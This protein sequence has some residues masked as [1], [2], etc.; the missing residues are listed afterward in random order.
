MK[1]VQKI[2]LLGIGKKSNASNK[3]RP[4]STRR[5]V[6]EQLER[7]DAIGSLLPFFPG[8]GLAPSIS[9]S[10]NAS[11]TREFERIGRVTRDSFETVSP[12]A[13]PNLSGVEKNGSDW[14]PELDAPHESVGTGSIQRDGSHA[15]REDVAPQAANDLTIDLSVD[16]GL[17]DPMEPGS[18]RLPSDATY[19]SAWRTPV[20]SNSAAATSAALSVDSGTTGLYSSGGV[21]DYNG[22]VS[23][24]RLGDNSLNN[25]GGTDG[26]NAVEDTEDGVSFYEDASAVPSASGTTV[27]PT[28]GNGE[29]A[30]TEGDESGSQSDDS[31]VPTNLPNLFGDNLAN[32]TVEQF[33][34]SEGAAGTVSALEDGALMREGD[35]FTVEMRRNLTVTPE[36]R[37][38]SFT[39]ETGFDSSDT[40][41]INDAFEAAFVDSEGYSLVKTF[42][43]YRDSFFNV[44]EGLDPSVGAQ[45]TIDETSGLRQ[46]TLDLTSV[47]DNMEGTLIFRM[48]NNDADFGSW[49]K[50]Y[51]TTGVISGGSAPEI[52]S[53]TLDP[54]NASE[55]AAVSLN[56]T[57]VDTDSGD[58][59]SAAINWGDGTVENVAVGA[60]ATGGTVAGSHVYADNGTYTVVLTVTDFQGESATF[61]RDVLVAN[62]APTMS[63][64]ALTFDGKLSSD[65]TV[66]QYAVLSG[67][68]TDP[69]FTYAPA[70]TAETFVVTV[71]WG[72]GS[73]E[74]YTPSVTQGSA[75]VLTFGEYSLR[76]NYIQGGIYN[77][78]VTVTDDDGGS[79]SKETRFG[80]GEITIAQ[81]VNRPIT[82]TPGLVLQPVN[83]VQRH[84]EIPVIVKS[85]GNLDATALDV[86]TARF[87]PGEASDSN[88]YLNAYDVAPYSDG[89]T[90]AVFH[91]SAYDATIRPVDKLGWLTA[92]FE[93]GTPFFGVDTIKGT[94]ISSVVPE[95][96][97]PR[98]AADSNTKFFVIDAAANSV[99]RYTPEGEENSDF[100]LSTSPSVR[101]ITSNVDGSK[102]WIVDA[103]GRA[104]ETRSPDGWKYG[105]WHALDM[106]DPQG[107]ATDGTDIWIVDRMLRSVLKYDGAASLREGTVT[108]DST[109]ELVSENM[110]P[111]GMATD[112]HT[113]WI[114]DDRVDSVFLYD[115]A[116]G[117]FLGSWALDLENAD[118]IGIT[119]DP[120]G[121]SDSIWILDYAD[122]LVYEYANA[123]AIVAGT[124]AVVGTFALAEGNDRPMGIV[125]PAV[126]SVASLIQGA[127]YD[128]D[129]Q[130][131]LSGN[132][133]SDVEGETIVATY[134]NGVVVDVAD[135][136]GNFF[137]A[138]Q[139]EPGENVYEITAI[140]SNGGRTTETVSIYGKTEADKLDNLQFDVSPSFKPDY[141]RTSFD[142]RL[143]VL[144]A[145]LAIENVGQYAADTPF[146]VGVRNI[147]DMNVVALDPVGVTKEG[148]PY[149]DVSDSIDGISLDPSEKTSWVNLSFS[150]PGRNRFT[151]EL[152]YVYKTNEAP[153]FVTA[154]GVEAYPDK[155]YSYASR[156]TDPNYDPLTYSLVVGP[157]GMTIDAQTGDLSWTPTELG[158]YSVVLRVEDGRGGSATQTYAINVV[159]APENRPPVIT[160][161]PVTEVYLTHDEEETVIVDPTAKTIV[162]NATVRDF[163]DSHPDFESRMGSRTGMVQGQ[164]GEDG[165]PHMSQDASL[166]P[167]NYT[168]TS[169]EYFDQWYN[170]VSGVNTTT[171]IP[172][173]LTETDDGSSVYEFQSGAFFPIDNQLFGNEGRNHNFHF[174]LECHTSF[175]YRGGE[176]FSFT[177]DDDIWVFIDG[178]LVVD[179]G[180]VHDAA[181]ASVSLDDLGLTPGKTYSFDLFFAER[182]TSASNF[183]IQTSI[184][185]GRTANYVYD[186]DATDPDGDAVTYSL[187]LAPEGMK[188]NASNGAITWNPTVDQIGENVVTVI[189]TDEHGATD[190]QTFSVMVYADP[191]NHD[192]IIISEPTTT[193][194]IDVVEQGLQND[195]VFTMP[196]VSGQV[197]ETEFNW[198]VSSTDY[199]NEFGIYKVDSADGVVNGV[200]P[201]DPNYASVA[202]SEGNYFVVFKSG[203]G[204]GAKRTLPLVAGQLYSFY[205]VANNSTENFLGNNPTN[206]GSSRPC[207]WF[208][209]PNANPDGNSDHLHTSV[210]NEGVTTFY[211]EDLWGLGDQDFNDVVFTI[212]SAL[213]FGDHAT[214]RYEV[215]AVDPD[216]DDITYELLYGPENSSINTQTGELTWITELGSYNF[217]VLASDGHG[218][219]DV[220]SFV[221]NVVEPGSGIISGY[222]INDANANGE[223]DQNEGFLANHVVWLDQNQNGRLDS[224]EISTKSDANG[225]YEFTGLPSG[226]YFVRYQ[227][228]NGWIQTFPSEGEWKPGENIVVNGDFE[229]AKPY[230]PPYKD[231][232]SYNDTANWVDG[233]IVSEGSVTIHSTQWQVANSGENSIDLQGL[234]VGSFSQKLQTIPG[235]KYLVQYAV[236]GDLTTGG[237]PVVKRYSITAGGESVTREFDTSG[238][239]RQNMGWELRSWMFTAN[240][241]E[242]ALTF[243]GLDNTFFGA[244]I[245]DVVVAPLSQ[246]DY[247][248]GYTVVLNGSQSA[249]NRNFGATNSDDLDVGS[250]TIVST[251]PNTATVGEVYRYDVQTINPSGSVLDFTL[252]SAPSGMGIHHDLGTIVWR[253][254]NADV[255]EY[256][257]VVKV[258]NAD[259]EVATQA[260]TIN[261]EAANH[262]PVITTDAIP[263][264]V[265]AASPY[266]AYIY[267]QDADNDALTYSL[268]GAPNGM[269]IDPDTGVLDCTPDAALIGTTIAATVVVTDARGKS[270][271]KTYNLSVVETLE[272]EAPVITSTPR[273]RARME[274]PYV[275]LIQA[276]DPNGDRL[277]FS[278]SGISADGTPLA[279]I[280]CDSDTGL[281]QWTP[282]AADQGTATITAS[283]SDGRGGVATQTYALDIITLAENTA[284]RILS[285]PARTGIVG[286]TWRYDA[287]AVDPDGDYVFWR[288]KDAPDGASINIETGEIVWVP[289]YQQLAANLFTVVCTD[290][291]GASTEQTFTVTVRGINRPPVIF[292]A[293]NSAAAT[294]FNYVYA[295]RAKDA[296]G[297]ELR[298][299]LVEGAYPE[300]MTIDENLGLVRWTPSAD[301]AG[302]HFVTI[303][304]DDGVGGIDTQT[305]SINVIDSALNNPPVITSVPSVATSVGSKYVYTVAAKDPDGDRI[306]YALEEGPE[307]ATFNA[308]TGRFEWSPTES[309]IG[310]VRIVF[311]ATDVYGK[312]AVQSYTL[313]VAPNQAPTIVSTPPTSA[314]PDAPYSYDVQAT[315]PERD[316]ITY[317][318][319][320]GPEGM[321]VDEYGRL[322]WTPDASLMN[323]SVSVTVAAID[324]YSNV[325]EQRFTVSVGEDVDA[326]QV[327]LIRD[328]SVVKPGEE[329]TVQVQAIDN[330]GVASVSLLVNGVEQPLVWNAKSQLYTAQLQFAN[331]GE[332]EVY[333]TAVDA[334]GNV[335][336]SDVAALRASEHADAPQITFHAIYPKV[337]SAETGGLVDGEPIVGDDL[338]RSPV[339]TYLADVDLSIFDD[340]MGSWIIDLA[341]VSAVDLS[342]L[343]AESEA[344]RVLGEGTGVISHRR[345]SLDPTVLANDAYVLRVRAYRTNGVGWCEAIVFG[346]EG[347]AKLGQFAFTT[348]DLH[349][350]RNGVSLTVQRAYDTA[351]ANTQGDFGYGWSLAICDPKIAE[352]T[353][354]G[355][356][357]SD[358][359]R[360]YLTTPDG[361]RIGFTYKPETKTTGGFMSAIMEITPRFEADPGVD[362]TLS[363]LDV[364]APK[365]SGIAGVFI[366]VGDAL[367]DDGGIFNPSNYVLTSKDGVS[368]YYRQKDPQSKRIDEETGLYKILDPNGIELTVTKDGIK[369]SAGGFLTFERDARGR[370]MSITDH[371]DMTVSYTY[372]AA[373]NLATFSNQI[374]SATNTPSVTYKYRN[375]PAHF[376][377]EAYD[378][379]GNR[380]FKAEFDDDGR[381]IGMVDALGNV[382]Q[383]EF[384]PGAMTGTTR[385][386]N[387]NVTTVWYD[388]RGNVTQE[389][390]AV[391]NILTGETTTYRQTYE[392]GDPRFPD[393]ETRVVNYD[394]TATEY[395]Y[396]EA[397][398]KTSMAYVSPDGTQSIVK[399]MAYD[400]EGRVTSEKLP[401]IPEVNYLY[402]AEGNPTGFVTATGMATSVFDDDGKEISRTDLHGNTTTMEYPEVCPC[403]APRLKVKPDGSYERRYW[404]K[405]SLINRVEYYNADDTLVHYEEYEYDALDRVVK[406][407]VGQG[408]SVHVALFEYDGDSDRVAVKTVVNPDDPSQ[409]Q[410]WYAFYDANGNLIRRVDPGVDVNDPNAGLFCKYDA[411]GNRIWIRD[412]VGNVTTWVYDSF[413]RIVEERD[414]SYWAERDVDWSTMTD[415]EI[416]EL[417]STPT[418]VPA[419]GVFSESHVSRFAYDG[420]DNIVDQIDP[421]GRRISYE[422]DYLGKLSKEIWY[423]ETDDITPI[424]VITLEHN[425]DG[426]LV[427]AKSPDAEYALTW[428]D[429]GAVESISVDYPW[430]ENFETFTITFGSEDGA[431]TERDSLGNTTY[432]IY[433]GNDG[434]AARWWKGGGVEDV[435][436]N[437]TYNSYGQLESVKRFV[438]LDD[439]TLVLSSDYSYNLS[440]QT[441]SIVHQDSLGQVLSELKYEYDFAGRLESETINRLASDMSRTSEYGYDAYGQIAFASYSG[442]QIDETFE[443]DSNGNSVQADSVVGDDNE[444]LSDGTY[445]YE[446]DSA[447]N[448]IAKTRINPIQGEANYVRYKYDHRNRLISVEQFSSK[449]GVLLNAES[450][451]YDMFNRR[452]LVQ[453]GNEAQISVYNSINSLANE[454]ARFDLDGNVIQR[455]MFGDNVDSLF[456]LWT[457]Q[458]G[459]LWTLSDRL[460]SI[461]DVMNSSG[462]VVQC[463]DYTSMGTPIFRTPQGGLENWSSMRPYGFT[464]RVW[465][466]A[467]GLYYFR[468]R[469]YDSSIGKFISKDPLEFGSGDTN[470]YRYI[471]N[472]PFAGTDP[473]GMSY[474][475]NLS[476]IYHV[477]L[478]VLIGSTRA[479]AVAFALYRSPDA[480]SYV[481]TLGP[482]SFA[483]DKNGYEINGCGSDGSWWVPDKI[484]GVDFTEACNNHDRCYQDVD[485]IQNHYALGIVAGYL[486]CTKNLFVD[487]VFSGGALGFVQ[488]T[489]AALIYYVGLTLEII[490]WEGPKAMYVEAKVNN[491]LIAQ[492]QQ[493]DLQRNPP[494]EVP[495]MWFP[496]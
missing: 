96:A 51:S 490:A 38:I 36:M 19:A 75:G 460:G 72:D 308:S 228:A 203:E 424:Y 363:C 126:I 68:F 27:N 153:I 25:G 226:A 97:D 442:S 302:L 67:T 229:K 77:A 172:L 230:S 151:Y 397:G 243:S 310:N 71:D 32:W 443:W 392:Y 154:P 429:S 275:Y 296:D 486:K 322:R 180:G 481:I 107:I 89:V 299:S 380:V 101:D 407:I 49:V 125:D 332:Y 404:N 401:G 187:A 477:T 176:T 131:V 432:T 223:Q 357:M 108:A 323:V 86:T 179:I 448:L 364:P 159:D 84:A 132:A 326:P 298:F 394:G 47:P 343:G 211:W 65:G 157:D 266:R 85:V 135:V 417:A 351:R 63:D 358:G 316:A 26:S 222:V 438:N 441:T 449:G 33:G 146:Y 367:S 52:T 321:T 208:A 253:P 294:E 285:T 45:T 262:A 145:E 184:E 390:K 61:S 124:A 472:T 123:A 493:A 435:G 265:L 413:D 144:Y 44:T 87:Y 452:I 271:S 274:L 488:A 256:Q 70:N 300:G 393:Y 303:Q 307:G 134:V 339:I 257:A 110:S 431:V 426:K 93:D 140:D 205:L 156:A 281:I 122:K 268:A 155:A 389:E 178:Q 399:T 391:T 261:V 288:L 167:N 48:V 414:P 73:V 109:F 10:L 224:N 439:P 234:G 42:S 217:T 371:M 314:V 264:P 317:A 377:E 238:S 348:T 451:R 385:D 177:G 353:Q 376:L 456:G 295:V 487:M 406:D 484:W 183:K 402:D 82:T 476:I 422:Y 41:S 28:V 325:A 453:N 291:Y 328:R 196:G 354:P 352:T 379:D 312:R 103:V 29:V 115:A 362:W 327:R 106:Y 55:G 186:V 169:E 346:V 416:R 218:G 54:E 216:D 395:V 78:V 204:E 331:V 9:K 279:G 13:V 370:I 16:L 334:A 433:D 446:Y 277:T 252:L 141:A 468:A 483:K 388:E 83:P 459:L 337:H 62:V 202:F 457:P 491:E 425:A 170:D 311:T 245:D 235:Q 267:A 338:L 95:T 378:K 384:D 173:T 98:V 374:D 369:H 341:P 74:D 150:N 213:F 237:N 437:I 329:F 375:N 192:P 320:Q 100:F 290:I 430:A 447:G 409:N 240:S 330:V 171:T 120:T 64:I 306:V 360:V 225:F 309:D 174:T 415:A 18:R 246:S 1:K 259:G 14:R 24:P 182:H 269:T 242:T 345:V 8:G 20:S 454:W 283:V 276:Y 116:T 398:N 347:A 23:S 284:P 37:A 247:T 181:S 458:D 419:N 163:H 197:V 270:A 336:Q 355:N 445:R 129:K 209:N 282:S 313:T 2:D 280:T 450:Y 50:L 35:S 111:T 165:K 81:P 194:I 470:M 148:I 188:I 80:Y 17:D 227:E 403:T 221:V 410:V 482:R 90:D 206:D 356:E 233:W 121:A 147:S 15:W 255:G 287:E 69:G 239:S 6:L 461:R 94:P 304:V 474:M 158:V 473:S 57:F 236:A 251:P 241:E 117:E 166:N 469:Y 480:L 31:T 408:E 232:F 361:D 7:R 489:A 423:D 466:N 160:T 248:Y 479:E 130:F 113:L 105:A 219:T 286:K 386:A 88:G 263:T 104:V 418:P 91:F 201:S 195:L 381:L 11:L 278:V 335:G 467:T 3:T 136:A 40:T 43:R 305:Y 133:S 365:G 189:A 420:S 139:V 164:L 5:S 212:D 258:R 152:V 118:P 207:V 260:F 405:H 214:Y 372:D 191:N 434:L 79:S 249:L 492:Y 254:T 366:S 215:V 59:H 66:E 297:D 324:S 137:V 465:D 396:D 112:G 190:T 200:L 383:Q 342:N 333:A 128:V 368:Y 344:Y 412:S 471:F 231:L 495:N 4:T 485:R 168:L 138:T 340:S 382:T 210:D 411:N 39:Y 102:L 175:T 494:F 149:Y 92:N 350:S 427:S 76:H 478:P 114:T 273:T 463:V 496:H 464:G 142:D 12:S 373:G 143:G 193:V 161:Y 400:S 272:N 421:N 198:L 30:A 244:M 199:S 319:V 53:F 58:V 455:F 387:G 127:E 428:G 60:T 318:L 359:D 440:G 475:E 119:N 46:V 315:D 289:T 444:L 462:S 301:D 34:G 56:A 293:P 220:Q 99:F 436:V 22:S 21:S 185:L 292:S 162:L 349:I 250:L